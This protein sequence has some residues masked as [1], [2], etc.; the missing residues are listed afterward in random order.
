MATHSSVLAWR[1]P[2][3][4]AWWAAVYGVTQ[5]R[6]RLKQLSSSSSNI[7]LRIFLRFFLQFIFYISELDIRNKIPALFL[8]QYIQTSCAI[9]TYFYSLA[10]FPQHFEVSLFHLYS[11]FPCALESMSYFSLVSLIYSHIKLLY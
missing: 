4:G 6:T 2:G 3:G 10:S 11:K 9:T 5:S 8:S 1:I 7:F